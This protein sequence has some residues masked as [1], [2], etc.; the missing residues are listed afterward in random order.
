M[1]RRGV[2]VFKLCFAAPLCYIEGDETEGFAMLVERFHENPLLTPEDIEPSREGFEVIG[3][4]NVGAFELEGRVGLLVRVAEQPVAD[5][6]EL[7]PVPSFDTSVYP[8]AAEA[9]TLRR[10]DPAWVFGSP[11]VVSPAPGSAG[12]H[13]WLTNLSHFRLAW[14][15][16]GRSFR[17]D[18]GPAAAVWPGNEYE[19][20]GIEDPRVTRIDDVYFITYTAVSDRGICVGLMTTKDFRSFDRRGLILP[21]QNKDVCFFPEKIGGEYVVLH[22][23]ESRWCRPAMWLARSADM[24]NW[25]RHELVAEPR[26]ETWDS[27]RIGAGPPPVA[28]PDGWLVIYHGAGSEGYC[29]AAMLLERDDPARVIARS[30]RPIMVPETEYELDGFVDS[31][32]FCNGLVER[33]GGEVW[34]YYGGG[35]RV[36]AGAVCHVDDLLNSLKR[37]PSAG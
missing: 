29:L 21:L 14:S 6:P 36:V 34:L 25:G 9:L 15:D 28:T 13:C 22:R 26:P 5:D 11:C 8:P 16:D 31:V 24:L 32:A 20:F 23:P 2:A 3:T 1:W 37:S 19:R 17:F 33:P 27:A 7:V 30:G 4:F 35:D 18:D 10:D 12:R